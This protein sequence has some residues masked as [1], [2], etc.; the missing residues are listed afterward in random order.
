MAIE[1]PEARPPGGDEPPRPPADEPPPETGV[2]DRVNNYLLLVY[3]AACLLMNYSVSGYLYLAGMIRL[4][5]ILPGIVSIIFPLY[6]LSRRSETGFRKQFRLGPPP[7]GTTLLALVAATSCILPIEAF[8]GI[9]ERMWPPDADYTSFILSI[10]P[11][12]APS[13]ALTALGLA[14]VAPVAEE[15]LFRGF[16]QRIFARNMGAPLAVTL[17]GALF[18]L[19]HFN[20]QILPGVLA[21]GILYG[22]LFHL[23]R[24]LWHPIIAHAVF[25]FVSFLRVHLATDEEIVSARMEL[26]HL[27]WVFVSLA[28]LVAALWLLARARRPADAAGE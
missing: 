8:S 27:A 7:L 28:V 5:L 1:D 4:S 18:A 15:L 6:L 16:V 24:S 12:G 11:K 3:A 23:T 9:F 25:N 26:P 19:A 10:K 2:F 17:A 13:F 21:L 20:A 22:A 14:V